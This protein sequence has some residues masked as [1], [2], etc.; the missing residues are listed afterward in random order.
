MTGRL[1]AVVGPSGVGKD[2]VMQALAAARPEIGIVKRVITRSPDLGG[3]DFESVSEEVFANMI[4]DGAFCLHWRAHGLAYG[5]RTSV[6]ADVSAGQTLLVNLSRSKL[7]DA[8]SAFPE[9]A[10]LN[11]TARPETLADRLSGR[12][13]E[14]AGEI[15]NRLKR[16]VPLP[17]GLDA[18]TITNDGPLEDTVDQALSA[19]HPV[20][21]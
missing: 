6:R 8:A 13:R 4:T 12:G 7:S 20:R 3:E 17:D 14:S 16:S 10:V 21:V 2:T 19:L 18:V 11:L 1:I 15:A 5:I 9:L